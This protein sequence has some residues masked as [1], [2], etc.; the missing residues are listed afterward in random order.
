MVDR[1]THPQSTN[2]V[3][4]VR[5]TNDP[6]RLPGA[7]V[8]IAPKTQEATD[9]PEP[10]SINP[11]GTLPISVDA[12]LIDQSGRPL[13]VRALRTR[14]RI[15]EE[16]VVLLNEKSLRDLRVIDIARRIGSS[17]ATFYQY[18]KDVRDV[19]LELATE[20]SESIPDLVEVIDGDWTGRD[21]HA[22]GCRLASLVIDYWEEYSAILRIRNNAADEGDGGDEAF[23]QIRI[24]AMMPMV[25]AFAKIIR[26]NSSQETAS[27]EES[28]SDEWAGGSI[29]PIT[30]A[31]A[32]VSGL[33]AMALH[34]K[35]FELR[36]TPMGEAREEIVQTMASLMQ[37][38]L[39]A[40]R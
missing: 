23:A 27:A 17:P 25:M 4:P 15:L 13:G 40:K 11:D 12:K 2:E 31:F 28:S 35:R 10:S 21:G 5:S 33:E 16:T 24:Q 37:M 7:V 34:R 3:P 26:A 38:V 39:T 29:Y 30:A 19:V 1:M 9:K 20:V 14:A 22:R 32:L 6:A 18:F 8:S 36:F